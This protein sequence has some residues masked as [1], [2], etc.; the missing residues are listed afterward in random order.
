MMP[1]HSFGGWGYGADWGPLPMWMPAFGVGLAIFVLWSMVWKGLA[2]WHSAKHS[3]GWW[4]VIL[5]LVNT[6]GIL[7]IA[8]LFFILKL[9]WEEVLPWRKR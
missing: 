5:M 2:L 6:A 3:Q 9:S 7:E 8:Y 1:F 4:F